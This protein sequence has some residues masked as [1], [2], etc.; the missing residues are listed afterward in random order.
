VEKIFHIK[1]I[2]NEIIEMLKV[3]EEK[4]VETSNPAKAWLSELQL[5]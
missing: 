4:F 5:N 1:E 3:E 2:Q